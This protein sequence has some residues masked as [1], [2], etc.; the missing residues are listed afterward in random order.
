MKSLENLS[1]Y[2]N[3]LYWL[4]YG[5][6]ILEKDTHVFLKTDEQ[7][8]VI[9]NCDADKVL[10]EITNLLNCKLDFIEHPA[11]EFL[12]YHD[13]IDFDT[14]HDK[15][16]TY[17]K[18]MQTAI[19]LLT[20]ISNEPEFSNIDILDERIAHLE[21]RIQ[22]KNINDTNMIESI[23]KECQDLN[24]F[25]P[26]CAVI[27]FYWG[28]LHLEL[29]KKSSSQKESLKYINLAQNKYDELFKYHTDPSQLVYFH[30]FEILTFK[31]RLI[32]NTKQREEL[33][34]LALETSNNKKL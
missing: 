24:V 4:E 11:K 21:K 30:Y 5:N 6:K 14:T 3:W 2:N 18:K 32:T 20:R 31:A 1:P 22:R 12:K 23:L 28:N 26:T 29:A 27:Y 19:Q 13:F 9:Y 7:C 16:N 8:K 33:L 34:K 15:K 25:D 17:L 10:I